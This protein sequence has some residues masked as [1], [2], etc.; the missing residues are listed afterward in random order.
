MR[1]SFQ[2]LIT[3]QALTPYAP[4]R[5]PY[6]PHTPHTPPY[7][8][9]AA[10]RRIRRQGS[11]VS[12]ETAVAAWRDPH[13]VQRPLGDANVSIAGLVRSRIEFAGGDPSDPA[14]NQLIRWQ[15]PLRSPD[16]P[17]ID[18]AELP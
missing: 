4:I 11:L 14:A 3:N 7:A 16:P 9:Y 5:P 13:G 12:P 6:A 18:P 10:I 8:A 1:F 17:G 15:A 2:L